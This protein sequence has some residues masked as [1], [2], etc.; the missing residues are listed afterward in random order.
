MKLKALL[1]YLLFLFLGAWA[2]F[3][4]PK[5][6]AS[7]PE[8]KTVLSFEQARATGPQLSAFLRQMPKGG[9]LHSHLSGAVYAESFVRWAAERELCIDE[10]TLVLYKASGGSKATAPAAQCLAGQVRLKQ[11][12]AANDPLLYRRMIDSWSM[13]NWEKSGK[14]GHDQ[15]FDSFG[16]FSELTDQIGEMVA[17]AMLRAE[18]NGVTYLELMLSLDGGQAQKVGSDMQWSS[19]Y[20]T[21][22]IPKIRQH[23][24]YKPAVD[25]GLQSVYDADRKARAVLKCNE[26]EANPGCKVEVRYIGQVSRGR[27][28]RV[29]LAQMLMAFEMAETD[30]KRPNPSLVGVNLVQPEDGLVAMKDFSLHMEMLRSLSRLYPNVRITLH[31]GEL[32][33]GLV[34]PEGL[35]SHIRDSV[36]IGGAKRIGHGADI[37]YENDSQSLLRKMAK[38]PVLVEICLT[39]NDQI[40]GM[41]G[42]DHPLREYLEFGVPVA[43]ATDDQGVA[44]SDLTT[45]Y[46]KAVEDQG[47]EYQQLKNIA[48]N[49]LEYAFV[50]GKSLWLNSTNYVE[51]IPA[52]NSEEL[53]QANVSPACETF[54]A[55]S[56]KARLQWSL[57][58]AFKAFERDHG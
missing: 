16:K 18:D 37:L 31:A 52:C 28:P 10:K 53:E 54:L 6:P 41:R 9:D 19:D 20:E 26:S 27:E 55:Q 22:I 47:L 35:R 40:L 8:E 11:D 46:K 15:F 1:A 25:A 23:Q 58:K 34:P 33:P 13:R 49:S 29:V 57:E 30:A 17:E 32:A 21:A 44:R 50:A 56:Q 43:L 12:L 7:T 3:L 42:K 51:M 45:E 14:S 2:I 48:R 38:Q 4:F 39:S 24:L 36:E 5:T